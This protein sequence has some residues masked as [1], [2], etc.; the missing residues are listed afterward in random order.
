M[1]KMPTMII[2]PNRSDTVSKSIQPTTTSSVGR[3][4]MAESTARV[5]NAPSMAAIMRCTTSK[6]I[7]AYTK[8]R[9]AVARATEY[10]TR[11]G[12]STNASLRASGKLTVSLCP[13]PPAASVRIAMRK[14][15]T[16]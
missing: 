13:P 14:R 8:T 16:S 15:M 7:S 3:L 10:R 1:P 11:L 5:T 9:I 4:L 2:I 6:M 12:W